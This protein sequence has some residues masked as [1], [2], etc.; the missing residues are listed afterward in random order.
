MSKKDVSHPESGQVTLAEAV[1]RVMLV[2]MP[3]T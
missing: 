1:A 2:A 3:G